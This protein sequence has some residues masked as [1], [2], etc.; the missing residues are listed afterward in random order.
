M[1]HHCHAVGCETPVP[2]K[3]FMCLKHWRMVPREGQQAVW[4]AYRA[5]Q[6]N[7]K[8]PSSI[9]M[10][11]T[12]EARRIV[13]WKEGKTAEWQAESAAYEHTADL[14]RKAEAA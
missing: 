9:Y 3:M 2:P 14:L 7:D 6:E 11:V 10:D 5:G 13:A 4:G 12:N 1:T 8:R